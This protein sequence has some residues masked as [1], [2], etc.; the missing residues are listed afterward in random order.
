MAGI[1]WH[2]GLEGDEFDLE[3]IAE[4]FQDEVTVVKDQHGKTQLIMELPFAKTE[5][6]NAIN[7][8]QGIIAKLSAINQ[9]VYKCHDS[10]RL[11]SIRRRTQILQR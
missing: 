7:A 4:L 11:G 2:F 10:V 3:S 5:L 9:I 8:A 1:E 6:R